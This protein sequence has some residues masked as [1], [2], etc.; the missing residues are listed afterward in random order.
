MRPP[1][2]LPWLARQA[3]L[4]LDQ[5]EAIWRASLADSHIDAA[6]GPVKSAQWE[7]LIAL[8]RSRITGLQCHRDAPPPHGYQLAP[9]D[10]NTVR[11][12]RS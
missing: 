7:Q 9:Q 1:K 8:V 11:L 4:P 12:R 6:H 2:I 5:A 3:S 10:A